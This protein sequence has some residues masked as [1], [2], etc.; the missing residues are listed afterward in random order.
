MPPVAGISHG[1]LIAFAPVIVTIVILMDIN[2][3]QG[4]CALRR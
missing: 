2:P 3:S 4:C 1:G